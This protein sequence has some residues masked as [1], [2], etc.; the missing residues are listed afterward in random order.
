MQTV[1]SIKIEEDEDGMFGILEID[2]K[3][4]Y[5]ELMERKLPLSKW[6]D[7]IKSK[8]LFLSNDE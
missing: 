1:Q 5:Q 7:W 3:P 4:Y 8:L 6:S 2:M